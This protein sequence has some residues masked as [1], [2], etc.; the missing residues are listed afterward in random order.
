MNL[1]TKEVFA[2]GVPYLIAVGACYAFGYWGAFNINILEFISFADVAKLAVYPLMVSL[3]FGLVGVLFAE[4]VYRPYLPP[5]GGSAT[6]MGMFGKKHWRWLLVLQIWITALVAIYAPEP[7]K[8]FVVAMLVSLLSTPLSH[9]EKLIEIVPNPRVRATTLFM[10]LLLPTVSF[11]YGR[12]QAFL[13]KTGASKQ[14]VDVVRSKLPLAGDEKNPVAYLGFLGSI[15]VLRE[16]KTGQVIFAK[17]RDDTP[18]F[19]VPR[20]Q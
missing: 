13:V 18:L 17:Q 9:L 10:L 16:A 14:F 11:A 5:G 6:K 3:I 19:L 4:L 20:S 2:I 15:Y 12:Q 8:W 7:E 1:G